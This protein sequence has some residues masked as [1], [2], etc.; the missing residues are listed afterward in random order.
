MTDLEIESRMLRLAVEERKI[1]VEILLLIIES[2]RRGIPVTAGFPSTF[3]WLVKH[4]GYSHS[5]AYRRIQSARL[6]AAVPGIQIK[7][8][9]GA[10]N[11]SSVSRTQVAISKTEQKTKVKV[12]E[13]KKVEVLEKI[14]HATPL[15][16]DKVIAVAFPEIVHKK[17]ERA[18]HTGSERVQLVLDMSEENHQ[19][20]KRVRSVRSHI[21]LR[22]TWGDLVGYIAADWLKR[23]DPMERAKAREKRQNKKRSWR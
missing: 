23:H 5:A 10:L 8:V 19:K 22:E 12:T 11:L 3:E 15:E 20:L 16:I 2:E 4:I 6:L 1:T 21:M 18:S 13:A 7:L 9:S 17:K 14:E